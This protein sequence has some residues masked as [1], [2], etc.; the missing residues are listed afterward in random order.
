M[1][2]PIYVPAF[3]GKREEFNVL[4]K[5]DFGEYIFPLI[6]I[7]KTCNSTVKE[8]MP[9]LTRK[10]N[11]RSCYLRLL[12]NIK[13][14]HVF[15]D[16]PVNLDQ[17]GLTGE[18][19]IFFRSII[20]DRNTR[21][22]FI[23]ELVHF[24]SKV[25][26]VVSTYWEINNEP[27]SIILQENDLR[28]SFNTLAFRIFPTDISAFNRDISQVTEVFKPQDYLIVD[29]EETQF[30]YG[31]LDQK[32]ILGKLKESNFNNVIVHRNSF[33]KD[34]TNVGLKH[35]EVVEKIDNS[36]LETYKN[37]LGNGFSDYAGIKK[38]NLEKGGVSSPGFIYYDGTQNLFYGFRYKNGG[39]KKGQ[40]KPKP[41]EFEKIIVPDVIASEATKN[42][43]DHHLDFLGEQ[44][45]GWSL[46]NDIDNREENGKSP[47]K[48]KR[49]SM[50]HY[51][52]CVKTKLLNGDFGT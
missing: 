45:H 29:W 35:N 37:Y 10:R 44:N 32:E 19:L 30:D 14:K 31:D 28:N 13:A 3:R 15:I 4:E 34:L 41:E 25:I 17:S 43:L 22:D 9:V 38:N 24:N 42:M 47:G 48:F 11:F 40:P 1:A 33:P 23:K 7:I 8:D 49:I 20:F 16:L 51:L 52:H 26:P 50:L 12:N 2:P 6:E 27:K 46:I 21:T 39:H 36:L 18:N 5:F